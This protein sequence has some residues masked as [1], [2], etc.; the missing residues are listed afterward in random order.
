MD[1]ITKAPHKIIWLSI[2][3]VMGLGIIG[4]NRNLDLQ[5]HDT[6]FVLA[7]IYVGFYSSLVLAF[8]GL[9]Y[10][11]VRKK[12]LIA[13]MTTLHVLITIAAFILIAGSG[14]VFDNRHYWDISAFRTINQLLT[15]VLLIALLSQFL[16]VVNLVIGLV[17]KKD[18]E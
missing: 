8:I 7:S 2:P 5:L 12:Q 17:G 11:L 6:Y 16:F 18:L 14:L 15:T 13:W 9:L 1:L 4:L 10:W 3:V